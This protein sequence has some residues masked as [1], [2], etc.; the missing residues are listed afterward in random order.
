MRNS[1]K[2]GSNTPTQRQLLPVARDYV[3]EVQQRAEQLAEATGNP[4]PQTDSTSE[5]PQRRRVQEQM[6]QLRSEA[7]LARRLAE[8]IETVSLHEGPS[9]GTQAMKHTSK[10]DSGPSRPQTKGGANP[11]TGGGGRLAFNPLHPSMELPPE[12]LIRLLSLETKKTRKKEA[13]QP[14]KAKQK[15]VQNSTHA[16]DSPP[17]EPSPPRMRAHRSYAAAAFTDS[18]FAFPSTKLLNP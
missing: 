16:D 10:T 7:V 18:F 4:P 9:Q 2:T 6:A 14:R 3:A 13:H 15:P 12:Q 17:A 11:P 5:R 8:Q 1:K